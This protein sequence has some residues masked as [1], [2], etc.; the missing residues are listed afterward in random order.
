MGAELFH[1]HGHRRGKPLR[2]NTSNRASLPSGCSAAIR[3][4][5]S[6]LFLTSGGEL[7]IAVISAGKVGDAW[8]A[9]HR[10]VSCLDG[11]T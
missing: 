3:A 11:T 8:F 4:L 6:F 7:L 2:R 5:P 9:G 10:R 1:V